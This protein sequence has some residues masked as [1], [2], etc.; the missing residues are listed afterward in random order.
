LLKRRMIAFILLIVISLPT[1]AIAAASTASTDSPLSST[2]AQHLLNQDRTF[3]LTLA[4]KAELKQLDK[5]FNLALRSNDYVHYIYS[6]YRYSAKETKSGTI[7]IKFTITYLETKAQSA[8]VLAEVKK[9]LKEIIKPNMTDFQKEK[10][11]HDYVITHVA[12]DTSLVNYSAY[13]ALT[14]GKTVCQGFALLTYRLLDEVGIKNQ[15]VEG[16]AGGRSHAWNLVHIKGNWY[17]LD[18]TWDDPVPFKKGRILDT[19]FNLTDAEL[20][21]DHSWIRSNYPAAN[22]IYIDKTVTKTEANKNVVTTVQELQKQIEAAM[23]KKQAQ[24][25]IQYKLASRNLIKDLQSA[26]VNKEDLGV[27]NVEYSAKKETDGI[28]T[29]ELYFKYA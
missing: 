16:Y 5:S 1:Q 8:Y 23:A 25:S 11:I 14:K 24:L 4:N 6:G 29:L 22:T 21:K 18:T 2:I 12:Y 7:D 13:A 3:S 27:K 26:V 28:I 19:Y 15:I 10:A 17:Q 9:I 20:Q